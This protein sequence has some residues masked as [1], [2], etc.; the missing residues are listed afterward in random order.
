MSKVDLTDEQCVTLE[1]AKQ[2]F[3]EWRENKIGRA[4]IPTLYGL[5]Q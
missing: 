1:K 4:R 5:Q 2:K 3:A